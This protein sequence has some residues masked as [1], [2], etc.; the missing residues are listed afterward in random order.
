MPADCEIKCHKT[1]NCRSGLATENARLNGVQPAQQYQKLRLIQQTVRVPSSIYVM[2]LGALATYQ[3]PDAEFGVNWNQM[4][5][6]KEPHIQQANASGS[7][8]GANSTK[9]SV[10]RLRPGA[11]SPGGIGVDIKH[12]SYDRYLNRLKG[13][14]PVKQQKVPTDFGKPILF[15]PAYPVYGGKTM[16][17]GIVAG[18]SCGDNARDPLLYAD[19]IRAN[20]NVLLFD[21]A[22]FVEDRNCLC[23]DLIHPPKNQYYGYTCSDS[24]LLQCSLDVKCG[25]VI[26]IL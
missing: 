17:T 21:P 8:P 26:P 6:R 19:S 1:I 10:T 14:R 12:N 25:D 2:N 13:K 16:K 22:C 23:K 24:F 11:L 7:N 3:E 9:R 4:S 18:C 5:D 20:L 15:N